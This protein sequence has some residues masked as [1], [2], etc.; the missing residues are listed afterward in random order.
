MQMLL[1][2]VEGDLLDL[3]VP[4]MLTKVIVCTS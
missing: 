1:L 3:N 2:Q 4:L